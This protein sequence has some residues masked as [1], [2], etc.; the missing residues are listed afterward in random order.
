[1]RKIL[2]FSD[3]T[4]LYGK[5]QIRV[6][7]RFGILV[8]HRDETLIPTS[9]SLVWAE[10]PL[11]AGIV[12]DGLCLWAE[13]CRWKVLSAIYSWSWMTRREWPR[14]SNV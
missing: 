6:S 4:V 12:P 2:L 8:L 14:R 13:L 9:L 3:K 10:S 7:I 1:M 5:Q 11:N